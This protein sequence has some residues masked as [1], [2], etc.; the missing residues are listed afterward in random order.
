MKSE[1]IKALSEREFDLAVLLAA[2]HEVQIKSGEVAGEMTL[3]DGVVH[4]VAQADLQALSDAGLPLKSGDEDGGKVMT[5]IPLMQR[6]GL[7]GK[8]VSM[9]AQDVNL[10]KLNNYQRDIVRQ[11]AEGHPIA[12]GSEKPQNGLWGSIQGKQANTGLSASA[13]HMAAIQAAGVQLQTYEHQTNGWQTVMPI[14]QRAAMKAELD[15]IENPGVLYRI[16]SAI[17][18]EAEEEQEESA[19]QMAPK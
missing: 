4:P 18:A 5:Y 16:R 15:K 19:E 13:E 7:R 3:R 10:E 11:L 8:L 1:K 9:R 6:L 14:H 17:G 2:G 12:H